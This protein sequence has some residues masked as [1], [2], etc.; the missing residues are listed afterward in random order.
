MIKEIIEKIGNIENENN[1]LKIENA[2]LNENID[3][4]K[5]F[6]ALTKVEVNG[7][8]NEM[9]EEMAGKENKINEIEKKIVEKDQEIKNMKKTDKKVKKEMAKIK[10]EIEAK[11]AE[12]TRKLDGLKEEFERKIRELE[13]GIKEERMTNFLLFDSNPYKLNGRDCG[14]KLVISDE[15]KIAE[16]LGP[17]GRLKIIVYKIIKFLRNELR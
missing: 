1:A 12:L 14:P 6:F 8:F 11:N 17:K 16:H 15:G 7:R 13:D 9:K 10:E 2:K 4:L 5:S 3:E